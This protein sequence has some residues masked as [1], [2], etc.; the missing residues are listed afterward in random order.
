[1]TWEPMLYAQSGT[2]STVTHRA[3]CIIPKSATLACVRGFKTPQITLRS[4]A[5]RRATLQ[6]TCVL[7]LCPIVRR[8]CAIR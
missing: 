3:F 2:E 1:M 7:S 6:S 5:A 8:S 4:F